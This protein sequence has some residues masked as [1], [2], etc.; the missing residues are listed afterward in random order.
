[1]RSWIRFSAPEMT[2]TRICGATAVVSMVMRPPYDS[3]AQP[4]R[5]VSTPASRDE[6]GER[7]QRV[8][9]ILRDQQLS[10]RLH[11]NEGDAAR[12]L[13]PIR[14]F[15]AH[16][17][18]ERR[19]AGDGHHVAAAGQL[20]AV[21]V[22][23]LR[24]FLPAFVRG[25]DS[26]DGFVAELAVPVQRQHARALA[27]ECAAR[28]EQVNGQRTESFGVQ[29]EFLAA[30]IVEIDGA[31]RFRAPFVAAADK[32]PSSSASLA[33]KDFCQARHSAAVP[34]R[35]CIRSGAWS[36]SAR[37]SSWT[38]SACAWARATARLDDRSH[39]RRVRWMC[40]IEVRLQVT[41]A[42]AGAQDQFP[43]A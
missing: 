30:M 28:R 43:A 4:S 16:A 8:A 34:P 35:N 20:H 32:V 14:L 5:A 29:H 3:P 10:Q 22:M 42:I 36:A 31:L 37:I 23:H 18:S 39:W 27:G 7:P 19:K 9:Q 15:V 11:A 41:A 13:F 12:I 40:A 1:M 24:D 17:P 2:A 21:I 33:A 38:V 6:Q 26:R 25:G